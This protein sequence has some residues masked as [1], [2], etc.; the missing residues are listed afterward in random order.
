MGKASKRSPLI[1]VII[2][3][4]KVEE[5][6][7]RCVK[8]VIKQTY[9][10]L[11]I[12]LVDDGSPD[13]CPKMCDEWAK[14]DKRIKV[15][16]KKNEG[17]SAA[18]NTGID[19]AKGDYIS[20]VDSDDWIEL[21]FCEDMLRVLQEKKASYVACGYNRV[22][23]DFIDCINSDGSIKVLDS[24]SFLNKLHSVQSGYGFVHMKLI[25]RNVVDG[26]RFDTSLKVGEDALFNAKL[27]KNID[28][29]IIYNKPLY[30]YY[31][32]SNSVVRKY[33]VNYV[34]KYYEAMQ[35]MYDYIKT[36]NLKNKTSVYNYIAYHVLLISVNYCYHPKNTNCR[37]SL[38]EVCNR[39]LFKEAIKKSNYK[40]MS[41]TR[42]ISL[43]TIKHKLYKLTSMICKYRQKQFKMSK[44]NGTKKILV[45]YLDNG[46]SSGINTY[47]KN[48][49]NGVK[50]QD[51][52]IEFL[53]RYNLKDIDNSFKKEYKI[54]KISRNRHMFKQ[55]SEMKRI[56]KENKYDIAYFNISESY[57]CIGIITAK[58]F[59][60]NKIVVHSHSSGVEKKNIIL[61]AFF[62]MLNCMFKPVV[63]YCSDL[64]L[65]CSDLATK[66]L[67]T[68]NVFD[69]N[70]YQII[71]NAI[72]D[73]KFRYNEEIRKKIRKQYKIDN[74][75][76]LGHVGRFSYVKNHK[77]LI[78]VFSNYL[79][80]NPNSVLI[81]I[82]DGVSFEDIKEYARKKGVY[83][84]I[85]FTGAIDNVNEF[86]QAFDCFLLPSKFEGLA[87]VG[88]EAQ[89]SE[90]KCIMSKKITKA[91]S[92]SNNTIFLPIKNSKRW[93]E[94]I[95]TERIT[96]NEN[97]ENYRIDNN[98]KQFDV[99]TN[100]EKKRRNTPSLL[101]K[102]LLVFHY[103][104]N[105][106]VFLNGFNYLM[107]ACALLLPLV[108]S[109][110]HFYY[111]KSKFKDYKMYFLFTL[112]LISYVISF[113]FMK[114]YNITGTAKILIWT[115]LHMFFI[116]NASY[117]KNKVRIKKEIYSLFK[118]IVA[119]ISIF[120]LYNLYLLIRR[121]STTVVDFG[122]KMHPIGLTKWGRFYGGFYDAN[123][124]SIV[125]ICALLMTVYL[126]KIC[127]S[128]FERIL[129]GISFFLQLVY[130]YYAQSRT[131]IVSFGVAFGVLVIINYLINKIQIKKL[132][133]SICL[134][135]ILVFVIP[136][137]SLNVYNCL[138][139]IGKEDNIKTNITVN[140][141]EKNNIDK[142]NK[143]KEISIGR[144][145]YSN[146]YSNGRISI[147]KTGFKIFKDNKIFGI[148]FSNILGYSKDRLPKSIVSKRNFEAFHNTYIDVLASQGIIGFI[149]VFVMFLYFT[150]LN[151]KKYK[152]IKMNAD[153]AFLHS[154]L[155]S[156]TITILV[157]SLFISQVFYVNNFVTFIFW[158]IAGYLYTFL[159][160]NENI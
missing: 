27:C 85:I 111:V 131:G 76:V 8:S 41:L 125:C 91:S 160:Y 143:K 17:V 137:Q 9:K 135:F 147:W 113:L 42:K 65:A 110:D 28:K 18:R 115:V 98:K 35:V 55:I 60:V 72:D 126:I 102:L 104:M 24:D 132:I 79:N 63:S 106:T 13:N 156:I 70:D 140:K 64:N 19:N 148:G 145:D 112:F 69:N 61:N 3:V 94:N 14:K 53:T 31:F 73:K 97:A 154:I 37:E 134:L 80:I 57:N 48:F 114:K 75:V 136:G 2:P 5:F 38:I 150:L 1:S 47:L 40:G 159:Q 117:L 96:L 23:D 84:K 74:K 108:M 33:D 45:G 128:K 62:R 103:F 43:F 129:L 86:I 133:I 153:S 54:H 149:I 157:S 100:N 116:F 87:I 89:F 93:A 141:N 25:K 77:F 32:N 71:Y 146:D 101:L 52:K 81:C 30:N 4:Y 58:L 10:H 82:G 155:L 92:I 138:S 67:Y 151:I 107:L 120:N 11:E 51:V 158:L 78:D 15:I 139:N 124:S 90:T 66:W 22:Y 34:D 50:D 44:Q 36:N 122:G 49:L 95:S 123:Y 6:L 7:D 130:I 83:D 20:F 121:V 16:H 26:I 127:K 142:S 56:I 39:P 152:K 12:I 68:K 88:L 144:T 119:T 99:I 59:G 109:V 21:S 118:T 29:A 105:L 46:N